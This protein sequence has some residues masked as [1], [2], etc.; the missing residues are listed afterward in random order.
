MNFYEVDRLYE[1]KADQEKIFAAM[2]EMGLNATEEN[3]RTST[4]LHIAAKYADAVTMKK[5][6]DAGLEANAKN[7]YGENAL[8]SLADPNERY[9]FLPSEDKRTCADL[10]LDAGASVMAR[11]EGDGQTVFTSAGMHGQWEL[12]D[13][14][15]AHGSK[16]TR[17][18]E[19]GENVLHCALDYARQ[20]N[21]P[22]DETERENQERYFQLVKILYDSGFDMDEKDSYGRS[23]LEYAKDCTDKRLAA[24]IEG[25]YS[26][27][28]DATG[29]TGGQTLQDAVERKDYDA[30][31]NI[32]A[33]GSDMNEI[34]DDGKW[35]GQTPLSVACS[36][37][38]EKAVELLLGLGAD[39]N[40]K[41]ADGQTCLC[42][43]L[44]EG[45]TVNYDFVQREDRNTVCK[46]ILSLLLSAGMD[47]DATVN[48]AGDTALIAACR[49]ANSKDKL[50]Y[51][52]AAALIASKCNLDASNLKGQN[53][54]MLISSQNGSDA[55][56]LQIALLEGGVSVAESDQDG[57]TALHYAARNVNDSVA[58]EMAEMLFEFDFADADAV[59][60]DGKTALEIATEQDNEPL[61]K[62]I[63]MNS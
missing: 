50:C 5:L 11:S 60:N 32:A 63:L 31:R 20:Y 47:K 38:D 43:V 54:L 9:G 1:S 40:F 23:P 56:E 19:N 45:E 33:N 52:F 46:K 12:I 16:L 4:L 29:L 22:S 41:N 51:K 62:L 28:T 8:F 13:A 59:N 49:R 26:E 57:N 39:P 24:L 25:T 35:I 37:L 21:D 14:A 44:A 18:N 7:K 58:K 36:Y 48:D 3:N 2:E 17:T 10:L 53:A 61:V 6:L 30:I 27:D 34:A 15:V 55:N 42:R